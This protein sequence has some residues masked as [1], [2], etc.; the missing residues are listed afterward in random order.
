MIIDTEGII[1]RQVKTAYGRRMVLLFSKKYGKISAGTGINERGRN[2][3]A[4]AMR[5]FTYGRYELFKNRESYNINSAEVLKSYYGLGEDVDKYMNSA[6]ILEFTEKILPEEQPAQAIFNLIL[7]FMQVMENR[8]KSHGT[9]VLGY[10]IKTLKI[11]GIMPELSQCVLCGKPC[12]EENPPKKF[13]IRDGGIVCQNCEHSL[14]ISANDTLI[15]PIN[16]GIV[17][18]LKYFAVHSLK[19]FENLALNEG[20]CKKLQK[21]IKHYAAYYL[22]IGELKSESFLTE[23]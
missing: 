2:K 20:V 15:Y 10:E 19:K 9:L 16:F 22:D 1:L 7:D 23:Y 21:M 4:L 8:Q 14:E 11:M 17:D 5:P 12:R 6:Y 18:I 13:S 3:S